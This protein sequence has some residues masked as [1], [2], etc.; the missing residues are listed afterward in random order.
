MSVLD[1]YGSEQ[2]IDPKLVMAIESA[3]RRFSTTTVE[4]I[5]PPASWAKSNRN[6]SK[7][8]PSSNKAN[9][10]M[11]IVRRDG[12][13]CAYCSREF[14]DLD[15]ATLDHVIPNSVVGHWQPWNLL[16]CCQA[17]NVLKD[18]KIPAVLMPLLLH[19][20]RNLLV[21]ASLVKAEQQAEAERKR[22][23][24]IKLKAANRLRTSR[25]RLANQRGRFNKVMRTLNG[26]QPVRL[27]IEGG[28]R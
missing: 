2:P 26:N 17:C 25:R 15:D 21:T 19:T 3:F 11:T 7:K 18:D 1:L 14:V 4:F 8:S 22:V 16:L 10:R 27:A 23:Q 6:G 13:R 5:R 24:N 20:L 28:Q 9:L 12:A